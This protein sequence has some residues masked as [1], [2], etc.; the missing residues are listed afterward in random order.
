MDEKFYIGYYNLG[1]ALQKLNFTE[2]S[3][4]NFTL[5][6]KFNNYYAEAYYNRGNSYRNLNKL[7]LALE[8]YH[9]AYKINPNLQYL[10]GNILNTK[11]DLCDWKNYEMDLVFLK[12][13]HHRKYIINP[14]SFFSI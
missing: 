8:D 6:I 4:K 3:I 5:A 10:F 1:N 13:I 14:F 2:K 12:N 9:S 7:E 11:K